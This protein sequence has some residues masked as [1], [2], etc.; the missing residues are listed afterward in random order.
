MS[1]FFNIK[2]FPLKKDPSDAVLWPMKKGAKKEKKGC[3]ESKSVLFI[4]LVPGEEHV[5]KPW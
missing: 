1:F 2:S 5:L 3:K 4:S